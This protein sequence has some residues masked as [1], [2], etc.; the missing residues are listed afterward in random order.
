MVE[1]EPE[2]AFGDFGDGFNTGGGDRAEDEGNV[3]PVR[4]VGE[5]LARLRPHQAL[6][7]YGGD[8]KGRGVFAAEEGGFLGSTLVVA[9]VGGTE[10]DGTDV[11]RIFVQVD[12]G[13]TASSEVVV[14]EAGHAL[15]GAFGQKFNRRVGGIHESVILNVGIEK[16]AGHSD[17]GIF[18]G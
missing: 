9:Q 2:V 4:G 1:L 8:A 14:R 13:H 15:T 3:L 7:A 6:E 18:L 10:F 17:F 11:A 5:D 12:L 16:R